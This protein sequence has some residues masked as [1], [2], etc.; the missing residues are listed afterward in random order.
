MDILSSRAIIRTRFW[1]N[2]VVNS[3]NYKFPPQSFITVQ[4]LQPGE[5]LRKLAFYE[6]M[7]IYNV[8]T[9]CQEP[10]N[11][12][13]QETSLKIEDIYIFRLIRTFTSFETPLP[14]NIIFNIFVMMMTNM[15]FSIIPYIWNEM[16]HQLLRGVGWQF[17]CR[18]AFKD[19]EE[20]L[21]S[22]GWSH[23]PFF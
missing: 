23:C 6:F 10:T 7:L 1:H 17:S 8:L 16:Y 11:V 13:F 18:I 5:I 20:F 21:L 22:I 9:L 3:L 15:K 12:N 4:E 19:I 14:G 2:D